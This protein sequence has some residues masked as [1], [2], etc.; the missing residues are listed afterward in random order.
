MYGTVARTAAAASSIARQLVNRASVR[1]PAAVMSAAS[2]SWTAGRN[3]STVGS[4]GAARSTG[5]SSP[6]SRT[7]CRHRRRRFRRPAGRRVL[8]ER[9]RD[10][11]AGEDRD[12]RRPTRPSCIV[13]PTSSGAISSRGDSGEP[14]TKSTY[15]SWASIA[16]SSCSISAAGH[17]LGAELALLGVLDLGV[18]ADECLADPA[19]AQPGLAEDLLNCV[20]QG[21][22]QA[23]SDERSDGVA[24]A[25]RRSP[26]P[27]RAAAGPRGSGA[28]PRRGRR[29]VPGRSR[30]RPCRS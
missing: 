19:E 24:R 18:D 26:R 14:D 29:T 28:R 27:R 15:P 10:G 4:G 5:S 6:G 1:P 7:G 2:S 8:G 23:L 22:R 25:A 9:C 20:G 11:R 12:V 30:R 16:V 17:R 13:G 21:C 3:F